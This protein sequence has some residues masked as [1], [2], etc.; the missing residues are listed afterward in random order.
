MSNNT[1]LWDKLCRVPPEH[2]KSFK[3]AG[4][5]QGTAIKPMWSIHRMTEI[6]GPVGDGW[7]TDEPQFQTVP[8]NNGE[9]LVYCTVAVWHGGGATGRFYGVGGDKV[10]KYT[11]ADEKYT[12][13]ER[14][15]NDDE[16]FKKAF[17]DAVTNALKHLGVGA[18]VHMGLWDGNK[19]VDEQKEQEP[20]TKKQAYERSGIVR[21]AYTK[22]QKDIHQIEKIGT[23]EDL[24]L[25]W[26]SNQAT[27]T[28]L[29]A[30][31]LAE[32]ELLKDDVK[33]NLSANLLRSG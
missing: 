15:E 17:T 2:L 27:I 22:L 13:P 26:K 33:A 31:W 12:R 9:V 3:R 29:P 7:G 5:F 14:W 21:D 1:E 23:V 30:D 10:V 25:Y 28:K 6:F 19:Y 4:G 8:G 24:A 20:P 11:R 16:A 18:D 32:L